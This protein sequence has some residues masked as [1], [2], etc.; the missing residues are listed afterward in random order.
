MRMTLSGRMIPT[1]MKPVLKTELKKLIAAEEA[2]AALKGADR[3]YEAVI[4]RTPDIGGDKNPFL[5]T[6]YIGAYAVALYQQLKGRVSVAAL[7]EMVVEGM[8]NLDIIKKLAGRTDYLSAEHVEKQREEAAWLKAHPSPASWDYSVQS[9]DDQ[10]L[11]LCFTRC[12]LYEMVK[13]EGVPEVA[14]L[15][16]RTDALVYGLSGFTM[17]AHTTLAEGGP[18]CD[19]VIKREKP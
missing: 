12:G 5:T 14:P 18:A 3:A 16:C 4:D 10:S 2:G 17:Q 15:L 8:Q 7:E 1:V 6:L 11:R 13:R 19:L 9:A